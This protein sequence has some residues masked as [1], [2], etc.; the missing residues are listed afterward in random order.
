MHSISGLDPAGPG[1]QS[2]SNRLSTNS[3]RYVE[4]IH[5]EGVILGIGAAIAHADFFPNGGLSQPGCGVLNSACSHGR[6]P[7]LFA[8]TITSNRFTARQCSNVSQANSGS[9]TGGTL[10]MGNAV[11][12]K[13]G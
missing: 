6:A 12:N 3:G 4:A 1:W 13:S 2:N 7:E 5:T 11:I 9:C 10:N 8:S